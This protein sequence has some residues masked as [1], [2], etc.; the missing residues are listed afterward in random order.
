MFERLRE[1][2]DAIMA[3]DPAARS[4]TEVLLCYPGLHAVVVHRL[5]HRIWSSGAHVLARFVSHIGRMLTGVEIHPAAKIGHRV[6]IDHG[7]GCV[8][9]ETA[10]V[11]DDV[12]LYHGVTLGGVSLAKTKRHP[13]LEAGVI[14]GAGAKVLGP[15]TVGAGARIGANAVVLKDVPPGVTM[16]GIPAKQALP[17]APEAAPSF[18][19]YGTP[20][21][22]IADP[23]SKGLEGLSAEVEA[24]RARIAALENA[25]EKPLNGGLDR[26]HDS[27][28]TT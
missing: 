27:R 19:A 1:D 20:R 8:I 15:I 17:R 21:P 3:R 4:R 7:M 9:G 22:D 6:F 13:T 25:P 16:L 12:T 23:L 18:H 24:L 2:I 11:G 5:S 14:V 26:A 28:E 10:E